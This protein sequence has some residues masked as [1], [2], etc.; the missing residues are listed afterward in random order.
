MKISLLTPHSSGLG[1]ANFYQKE[2][3]NIGVNAVIFPYTL[4]RFFSYFLRIDFLFRLIQGFVKI[5]FNK[6]IGFNPD[7]IIVF[8]GDLLNESRL[9]DLRK[10]GKIVCIYTDHPFVMP[11][12]N[13]YK[14]MGSIAQYDLIYTFSESLV[15][16]F[17]QL[18]AKKVEYLPFG[19]AVDV[20]TQA[21]SRVKKYDIVYFGSHGILQE[22]WLSKLID[23]KLG[24]FGVGWSNA[25][26]SNLKSLCVQG[27]GFGREMPAV[28]SE[29]VLTFNMVR[30]EHGAFQSMK[31]FEL[32]AM[33]AC[34]ICHWSP[35]QESFFSEG[36]GVVYYKNESELIEKVRFYLKNK[37]LVLEVISKGL[38]K[39]KT[40]SYGARVSKVLEDH[41]GKLY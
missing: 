23:F 4:S 22:F 38:K 16:V 40:H 25:K 8:R 14:N 39:V 17:Y 2:F 30:A 7:L 29:S 13:V 3:Q 32:V 34:V 26:N 19:Y 11:G 5:E 20:H 35:E 10:I 31:T 12:N 9:T 6:I 1:L 15:P 24:I 41:D 33:G 27:K 36:E 37:D 21:L 28:I 18:G